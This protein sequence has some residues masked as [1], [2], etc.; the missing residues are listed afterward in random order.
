VPQLLL[1]ARVHRQEARFWHRVYCTCF[2]ATYT[3]RKSRGYNCPLRRL[4]RVQPSDTKS[5]EQARLFV[6]HPPCPPPQR[7]R[8]FLARLA[9]RAGRPRSQRRACW[10][11][12]R[13]ARMVAEMPCSA[14]PRA[15]TPAKKP[16]P[17]SCPPLP[18]AGEGGSAAPLSHSVGEGLGVR[19]TK[20]AYPSST[21]NPSDVLPIARAEFTIAPLLQVPP[22]SRG[23]PRGARGFGSPCLQGEP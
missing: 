7:G 5:L 21:A 6:P 14:T 23:E 1:K 18:Q 15:G 3:N 16:T 22:A 2:G 13:L 10:E 8:F 17:L 20:S 9:W 12:E 11:R 4:I 19:A